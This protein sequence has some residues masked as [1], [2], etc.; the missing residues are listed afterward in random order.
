M[1]LINIIHID[2]EL[3]CKLKTNVKGT[4]TSF[5][6]EEDITLYKGNKTNAP[7]KNINKYS[8]GESNITYKLSP[9]YR[10]G[11]FYVRVTITVKN[12]DNVETYYDNKLKE[13]AY[14]VP[15]KF[16]LKFASNEIKETKPSGDYETISYYRYVT[17]DRETIW[18]T[19]NYVEGYI[20][21]GKTKVE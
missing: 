2:G 13:E 15:L 18:S 4:I 17:T 8:L 10:K 19:E 6:N 7:D 1:Y 5:L 21:T 14:L 3:E 9:Y 20:K 16:K 12:T 11:S